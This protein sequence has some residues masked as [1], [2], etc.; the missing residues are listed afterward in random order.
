MLTEKTD[1]LLCLVSGTAPA[2]RRQRPTCPGNA[3]FFLDN[4]KLPPQYVS[5]AFDSLLSFLGTVHAGN[6]VILIPTTDVESGPGHLGSAAYH[7]HRCAQEVR[8][9]ENCML[10]LMFRSQL[11][12][13]CLL[14]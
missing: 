1:H 14:F 10:Y 13:Y 3:R 11:Q 12:T 8:I 2:T 6:A 4:M 9:A 5:S 7:D